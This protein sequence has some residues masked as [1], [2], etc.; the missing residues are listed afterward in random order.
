MS[1][2]RIL[3]FCCYMVIVIHI[4]IPPP[5]CAIYL[6]RAKRET[7][8]QMTFIFIFNLIHYGPCSRYTKF[9]NRGEGWVGMGWVQDFCLRTPPRQLRFFFKK[10]IFFNPRTLWWG[11]SDPQFLKKRIFFQKHFR[12]IYKRFLVFFSQGDI[13][14]FSYFLDLKLNYDW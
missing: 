7:L 6:L 11:L 14:C 10:N 12:K 5:H 1:F 4:N 9:K 13:F 8:F 2:L 3:L